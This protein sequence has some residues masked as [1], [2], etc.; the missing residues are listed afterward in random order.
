MQC[1]H[2][3]VAIHAMSAA[4]MPC[5]CIAALECLQLGAYVDTSREQFRVHSVSQSCLLLVFANHLLDTCCVNRHIL[6]QRYCAGVPASGPNIRCCAVLCQQGNFAEDIVLAS[7]PM[8][9]TYDASCGGNEDRRS[10]KFGRF[11]GRRTSRK[12]Q[13]KPAA[14]SSTKV[15][16][17][18]GAM[19][20]SAQPAYKSKEPNLYSGAAV[21]YFGPMTINSRAHDVSISQGA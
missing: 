14:E 15:E 1:V 11:I 19:I 21:I 18:S 2:C 20:A 8:D 7:R 17:K 13:R 12:G 9:P 10:S 16:D 3:A 6:C 5:T 4:R